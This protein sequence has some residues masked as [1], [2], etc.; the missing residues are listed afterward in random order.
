MRDYDNVYNFAK[1]ITNDGQR[2]QVVKAL[3][4]LRT[5]DPNIDVL[6]QLD[7]DLLRNPNLL[8]GSVGEVR[9]WET[10]LPDE[11]LRRDPDKLGKVAS[12]QSDFGESFDNIAS[13]FNNLPS[14]Q[15]ANW[16]DYLEFELM[17]HVS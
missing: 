16:I 12:Y 17:V 1:R 2:S 11:I 14:P 15:R 8:E 6:R 3:R 7:L 5:T 9:A 10:I 4:E 13:E